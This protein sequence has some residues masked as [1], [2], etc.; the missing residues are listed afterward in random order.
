[1]KSSLA[2]AFA[3]SVLPTHVGPRNKKLQ[4][5]FQALAS[6]ALALLITFETLT[7]ALSCHTTDF[8]NTS[9]NFKSFSFSVSS[10][11]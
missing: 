1:L 4:R 5:G 11:F 6:H 7:I 3:V 8:F 10:N 2:K 9:S